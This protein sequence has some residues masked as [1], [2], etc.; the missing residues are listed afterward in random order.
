MREQLPIL[1]ELERAETFA[2]MADWL[3]ACPLGVFASH[4]DGIEFI[5]L[6]RDFKAG[7]DYSRAISAMLMHTRDIDSPLNQC[8]AQ[9]M[10]AEASR[11]DEASHAG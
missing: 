4:G 9:K 3:A 6:V 5:C 11:R 1:E 10:M 8:F 2:A 7:A